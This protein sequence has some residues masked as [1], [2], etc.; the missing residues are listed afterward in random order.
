MF[1]AN[2]LEVLK[3]ITKN[4]RQDRSFRAEISNQDFPNM[5]Q[6]Y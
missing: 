2:C 1:M 6:E 4:M 3:K 5:R